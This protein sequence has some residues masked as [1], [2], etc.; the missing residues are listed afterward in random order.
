MTH[1]SSIFILAGGFLAALTV[2][3]LASLPSPTRSQALTQQGVELM[4][5]GLYQEALTIFDDAIRVDA[6]NPTPHRLRADLLHLAAEDAE[7]LSSA[8]TAVSISRADPLNWNT[9]GVVL[10]GLRCVWPLSV[11]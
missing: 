11:E 10:R 8:N 5:A 1:I 7:A 9:L 4:A 2:L 6:A 3:G